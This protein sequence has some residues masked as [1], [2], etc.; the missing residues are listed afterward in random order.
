[1]FSQSEVSSGR[2]STTSSKRS[3]NCAT[4]RPSTESLSHSSSC[5]APTSPMLVP[6]SGSSKP[7]IDRTAVCASTFGTTPAAHVHIA[8]IDAI[9]GHQVVMIQLDDGP[10]VPKDPD[11]IV[12]TLRFRDLPGEGEFDINEFLRVL[13]SNGVDAPV[14]VEVMDDRMYALSPHEAARRIAAASR[15]AI[16]AALGSQT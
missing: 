15:T 14:S 10:L 16:A 2:S 6:L 9:P 11:F 13:W 5:R 8:Q 1:M 12:D 7:L 4:K 3:P